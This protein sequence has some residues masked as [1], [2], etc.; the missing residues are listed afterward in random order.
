[1]LLYLP[2]C[3]QVQASFP[4]RHLTFCVQAHMPAR[5]TLREV[6]RQHATESTGA[7]GAG[8]HDCRSHPAGRGPP[9][10]PCI[11][12]LLQLG[13]TPGSQ[14]AVLVL[15]ACFALLQEVARQHGTDYG[16]TEAEEPEDDDGR[17]M[18]ADERPPDAGPRTSEELAAE[19]AAK[20]MVNNVALSL[21]AVSSVSVWQSMCLTAPVCDLGRTQS[22][23]WQLRKKRGPF[24]AL[25]A[26]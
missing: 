21:C 15:T 25:F 3:L 17:I 13:C 22:Q 14:T 20:E 4:S 16:G 5:L 11:C 9:A 18:T 19:Q 24:T 23:S 10:W 1:M 8:H 12:Q 2:S 6:A 7:L 26:R